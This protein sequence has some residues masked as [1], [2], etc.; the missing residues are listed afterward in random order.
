MGS[1]GI[2]NIPNSLRDYHRGGGNHHHHFFFISPLCP[3]HHSILHPKNHSPLCNFSTCYS[4]SPN[5][6]LNFPCTHRHEEFDAS[7]L[8]EDETKE[9]EIEQDDEPIFVLTDEWKDLFAKSEAK[10]RLGQELEEEFPQAAINISRVLGSLDQFGFS[11]D[12]L[13]DG[14]QFITT[15]LTLGVGRGF[16]LVDWTRM[17]S[18]FAVGSSGSTEALDAGGFGLAGNVSFAGKMAGI[19]GGRRWCTFGLEDESGRR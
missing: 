11:S 14:L 19:H 16:E 4:A 13:G 8:I 17:D 15:T 5:P 18:G 12:H 9:L 7:K 3:F 2:G 1:N 6:H 10:R